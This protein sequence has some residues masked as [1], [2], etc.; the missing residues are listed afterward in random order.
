M[1]AALYGATR[2]SQVDPFGFFTLQAHNLDQTADTQQRSHWVEHRS[3]R[4][5]IR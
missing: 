2:L 5:L 3:A 1:L 4:H